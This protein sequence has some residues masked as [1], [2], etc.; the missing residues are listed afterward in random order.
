MDRADEVAKRIFGRMGN[1][2]KREF[3]AAVLAPVMDTYGKEFC[4][5][6]MGTWYAVLKEFDAD[7]LKEGLAKAMSS[8]K[9]MPTPANIAEACRAVKIAAAAGPSGTNDGRRVLYVCRDG[10]AIR[11]WKHLESWCRANGR[12]YA[13]INWLADCAPHKLESG[14]LHIWA[15][16]SFVR[17]RLNNNATEGTLLKKGL[18]EG[19]RG[20]AEIFRA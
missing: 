6:T 11:A 17:D 10:Q 2:G 9:S 3:S 18:P 4:P 5:E 16:T 15:P 12:Q 14:T 7:T 19:V 13:W 8:R 20:K 1:V